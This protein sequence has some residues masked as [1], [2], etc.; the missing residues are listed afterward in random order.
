MS[1]VAPPPKDE[2]DV[3][4]GRETTG[5]PVTTVLLGLIPI[6]GD[7]IVVLFE[8]VALLEGVVNWGLVVWAWL[9]QHVVEHTGASREPS[10]V[11]A[12][13]VD[14]KGL[15]IVLIASLRARVAVG[16][17]ALLSSLLF[18][19]GLFG[20]VA[21][22]GRVSTHLPFFPSKMAP[23]ASSL[24][25][26]LVVMSNSSLESTGRLRPSSRTR[27]RQVMPSRKP[28]TISD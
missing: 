9:L 20:L 14:S 16:L 13:G 26:K 7:A 15:V 21:L 23:T 5:T 25:A 2:E 18:L 4:H 27:S 11:L 3:L 8:H 22:H 1:T 10:R 12:G 28:C 6:R 24:E 19:R 17:L